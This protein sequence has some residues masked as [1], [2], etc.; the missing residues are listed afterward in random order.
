M[1]R[2][3]QSKVQ[4]SGPGHGSAVCPGP[5]GLELVLNRGC[6]VL[7]SVLREGLCT[8]ASLDC[9]WGTLPEGRGLFSFSCPI[10]FPSNIS[11]PER[12]A[13]QRMIMPIL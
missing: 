9:V 11:S 7:V 1:E 5:A 13:Y 4:A 8:G 6:C 10:H 12:K 3:G 2:G